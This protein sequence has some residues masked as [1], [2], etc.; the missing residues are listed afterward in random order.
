[1]KITKHHVMGF[2]A[3]LV[4][5]LALM[6]V[7]RAQANSLVCHFEISDQIKTIIFTE[8][9]MA[10][11]QSTDVLEIALSDNWARVYFYNDVS[12]AFSISDCRT[13][14]SDRADREQ[15]GLK[16]YLELIN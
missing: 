13:Y 12:I 6:I 10:D 16:M 14:I 5:M 1:M 8:K 2:I 4:L 11:H 3:G 9:P 7:K 15:I